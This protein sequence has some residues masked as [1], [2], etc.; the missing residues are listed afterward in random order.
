MLQ[1]LLPFGLLAF[2]SAAAAVAPNNTYEYIVVGS[3]PGGGPLAANL[4]RAGH[5]VLLL[6]AGQDHGDSANVSL[7]ANAN[8]A[9]NDPT[10]RWD[11]FVK[12]SSDPERELQYKYYTWRRTD[13][14]FYVGNDPPAGAEPLGIWYPRAGTLGGC[15]THNAAVANLPRDSDWNYIADITGD[16]SWSA[17][18]MRKYFARLE[19]NLYLPDGTPG[20]GFRGYLNVSQPIPSW[21]VNA[22]DGQA[23]AQAAADA[24]GSNQTLVELLTR[25]INSDSPERDSTTGLFGFAYHQDNEGRRSS[26]IQYIRST[27]AD[28]AASQFLTLQLN[29]LVSKVLFDSST[30]ST[31]PVAIG[32]EYLQGEGLYGADPRSI[33]N[34]STGVVGRAYATKEVILSGG[35]YNTPQLLKLSGIGPAEELESFDI[36]VVKD[37]PGVGINLG[38]NYEDSIVALASKALDTPFSI[39]PYMFK[40]SVAENN[41]FD[42][43]MFC[44]QFAF[45]GYWPNFPNNY[46]PAV[47]SCALVHIGPRSQA[48]SVLLRSADPRDPPEIN[49]E[50]FKYG[51]D[52]DIQALSDS[53]DWARET[54]FDQAPEHL[55]PWNELHPLPSNTT[56][57][58][59]DTEAAQKEYL[60]L[61]AHGHHATSTASIGADDDVNAV[62]DSEFR[63]RG[64]QGLRVV[65]GSAFPIVPGAFPVLPTFMLSEKASDVILA[66]A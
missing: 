56:V 45:E 29:T 55:K 22:S 48:G 14:S 60:K 28:P 64:V 58:G 39:Y 42:V 17:E 49:F 41:T 30:N 33:G 47:Y 59:T 52:K 3:G 62:L 18:N 23:I 7:V 57:N 2:A 20:H 19:N 65:D 12:H 44:G 34:N 13:G 36:P 61:Q 8:A 35:V 32:V 50:F 46:G 51:G 54:L 15:A 9:A 21:A 27:L 26:P 10:Q 24:S 1:S 6:E 37:L 43:Y 5:S 63:V 66:A 53:I 38:D 40:S 31:T 4:A 16:S 11:F 25:D